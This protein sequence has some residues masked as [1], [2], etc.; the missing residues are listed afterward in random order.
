MMGRPLGCEPSCHSGAMRSIEPGISRFPMRN[1][2]SEVWS[3]GPSRNDDPS[4]RCVRRRRCRRSPRHSSPRRRQGTPRWRRPPR[5]GRA[6]APESDPR[7]ARLGTGA[8]PG[9]RPSMIALSIRLSI[10][11]GQTQLT[12]TRV[13]GAFQRGA[14]GKPDHRVLA[15]AVDRDVGGADQPR[16][17]GGIDDRALVLL[18]HHRQHVLHAQEYADHVD[19]EHP[20]KRLQRIFRDRRDVAL[21][22]GI[23]V[24]NVD[25]AEFVDRRAHVIRDLVL[26]GDI[27]RDRKRLRRSRQVLDR[28]LQVRR[29]CGR[30]QR[31]A[32]RARPK[33]AW[34]QFR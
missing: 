7:S 30:R 14:L 26:A 32:R 27:G 18:Q 2:A 20:T 31:C 17:R 11:P 6:G 10:R 24:E 21:D 23:V 12:R 4:P 19:V 1:C 3:F 5:P 34:S 9:L 33:A 25:G 29:P 22:A 16:D 15:G 13:A 28:G 8:L